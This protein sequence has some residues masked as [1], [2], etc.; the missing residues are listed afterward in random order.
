ME[1]WVMRGE[2]GLWSFSNM[3]EG[4]IDVSPGFKA[5]CKSKDE[6]WA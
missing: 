6:C 5:Y 2:L 1:V 3:S 4:P